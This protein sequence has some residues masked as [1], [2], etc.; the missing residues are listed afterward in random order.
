MVALAGA[1]E[2]WEQE[3]AVVQNAT[4]EWQRTA[5]FPQ[6]QFWGERAEKLLTE[7]EARI[8]TLRSEDPTVEMPIPPPPPRRA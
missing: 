8:A 1:I 7:I 4:A 6:Q 3:T 5:H 2:M